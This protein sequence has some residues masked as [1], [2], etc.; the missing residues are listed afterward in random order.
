MKKYILYLGFFLICVFLVIP[1][2]MAKPEDTAVLTF[3]FKPF[4]LVILAVS[5]ILYYFY[6]FK[7]KRTENVT[8]L[9]IL[10]SFGKLFLYFGL[11]IVI[12][13]LCSVLGWISGA[14]V[15]TSVSIEL[16]F[17][18]VLMAVIL[19]GITAFYEEVLYRLYLPA[20]MIMF[21]DKAYDILVKNKNEK[22]EKTFKTASRICIEIISVLVFAFSHFYLGWISVLN[23][24][25]CGIILRLCYLKNK[26]VLIGSVSHW[27]YNTCIFM[28]AVLL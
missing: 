14:N 9:K 2:F 25:L 26:T 6:E 17:L 21:S 16:K 20:V 23:A 28:A 1:P 15:Q 27:L 3:S 10:L 22:I 11:L 12:Q 7:E 19:L 13:T 8:A 4:T 24:F 18:P 5:L